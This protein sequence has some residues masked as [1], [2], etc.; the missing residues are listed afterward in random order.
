MQSLE[1]LLDTGVSPHLTD[2]DGL[3]PV[4]LAEE[5]G[6]KQCVELLL[7]YEKTVPPMQLTTNKAR[8]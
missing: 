3:R 2:V 5:C 8:Q 7:K 1:V 4:D 6:H